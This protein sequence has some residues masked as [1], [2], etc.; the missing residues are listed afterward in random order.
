[1][2]KKSMVVTY[3]YSSTKDNEDKIIWD[4]LIY[5][6]GKEFTWIFFQILICKVRVIKF[7]LGV[8]FEKNEALANLFI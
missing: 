5:I 2:T 1:M 3:E 8:S 6:D 4:T 7:I